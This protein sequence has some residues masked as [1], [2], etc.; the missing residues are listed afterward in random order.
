L[1]GCF[2]ARASGLR[3]A[4][5]PAKATELIAHRKI[6]AKQRGFWQSKAPYMRILRSFFRWLCPCAAAVALPLLCR[7]ADKPENVVLQYHFVGATQLAQ[8]TSV[9]AAKNVFAQRA[10]IGFEDLILNRLAMNVAVTFHFQTNAQ[11]VSLLRPL[12]DDALLSESMASAGGS[13]GQPLDF[14][15]AMQLDKDHAQTWQQNLQTNN[16][17]GEEFRAEPFSGWQWNKGTSNSFWMVPTQGWL[18]VGRGEGLASVRSDYLQQI[19]KTGR[20]GPALGF[21]CFEA[22]VD[23]ARLA[24]WMALSSCPLKLGRT[25]M[26]IGTENGDFHMTCQVTY[27]EAIQWQPHPMSLPT[28]LV[29]EPLTSFATGQNVEPFLKSD[30]SLSRLCTNPLS[31][32]FYF[33]SMGEMPF[34][35]YVAWPVNNPSNTI[36]TL[37]AQA[38]D[39]LNPKLQK[40]DGTELSWV[41]TVSQLVWSKLQLIVPDVAP[42]PAEDGQFLVG[43]LFPLTPGKGPAPK[44]L[45]E[46]FEGRTD[47]VYYDW[48]LTGPRVRQLL[49]VTQT[50]PILQMLGVGPREPLDL[51][52]RTPAV[53]GVQSRLNAQEQ[54]L[55]SLAPLLGNTVTE[56]T[57]T[58]PNEL[59]VIRNSSF[60]FSSL[61]LVLLSHWLSDT[62]AGPLD[63]GLLPQAKMSGPGRPSH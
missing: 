2:L 24:N 46:Q 9:A 6:I 59:T 22:D 45:W 5:D 12:L 8:N 58:G 28:N 31:D 55:A 34:Q 36:M 13:P 63:W 53:I 16:G 54:W 4:D 18:L 33:W 32:Q 41:P 14:V 62:P 26:A 29:C 35:S 49:T 52:A 43:G 50:V 56:V 23:W 37:S 15:L 38:I 57:K 60:V 42:A 27:P 47:L 20:P 1:A 7:G 51:R 11:T 21:N 61:E 17:P 3:G 40:L 48:E 30:E 10:T 44:A 19:Q 39:E 25:Q